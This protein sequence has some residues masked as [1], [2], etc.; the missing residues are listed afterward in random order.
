MARGTRMHRVGDVQHVM[1]H[2]VQFL[3]LFKS[4]LDYAFFL[5]VLNEYLPKYQCHCY[6]FAF[7][8][9]HYH[10]ILRPS[11]DKDHFS[12][13]MKCI[14]MK[15]AMYVNARDDRKGPVFWDRF[16]S[17]PTRD[18]SY[19]DNLIMYVH[20]NP[21]K[22]GVVPDLG[23]LANYRWCSHS[24]L[25]QNN[26]YHWLKTDYMKSRL[27][28]E[29]GK[30]AEYIAGLSM[31]CYESFDPWYYDE[32]RER[33]MPGIPKHARSEESA[34]VMSN[35]LRVEKE[36]IFQI[37]LHKRSN[38]LMRLLHEAKRTFDVEDIW[39]KYRSAK[40]VAAFNVFSYW[41]VRIAGYSGVLVA[42]MFGC[43]PNTVLRAARR[44]VTDAA[45]LPFPIDLSF[46]ETSNDCALVDRLE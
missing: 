7:M 31:K 33:P 44:G 40:T 9:N 27:G 26:P 29:D 46:D 23:V 15:L 36:R 4:A 37:R 25:F 22:G 34:W 10:L 45:G 38:I 5:D 3:D 43:H 28:L 12:N 32:E 14:N 20:A 16:K 39:G 41:A 8:P 24:Y 1:S 2:A 13:M 11:G 18:L 30:P 42:R 21:V 19:I 17:I 6:G 35:I